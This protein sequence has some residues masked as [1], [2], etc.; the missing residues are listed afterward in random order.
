MG[1]NVVILEDRVRSQTV[2]IWDCHWL[3]NLISISLCIEIASNEDKPRFS[4][5]GD[6][7]P[8]QAGAQREE[9]VPGCC[10]CVWFFHTLLRLLFVK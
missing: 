9:E 5:E 1:V 3:Q 4:S 10:G 6:A 7:A 8:H 2:E